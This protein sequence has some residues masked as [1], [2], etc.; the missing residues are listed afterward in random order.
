MYQVSRL[1]DTNKG[2]TIVKDDSVEIF[3]IFVSYLF[4]SSV[5]D[6]SLFVLLFF[7]KSLYLQNRG[8]I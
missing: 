6:N 5:E 2:I 7:H 4:S 1:D 3:F 8:F